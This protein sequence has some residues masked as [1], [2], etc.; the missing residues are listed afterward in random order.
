M[1]QAS[2]PKKTWE[3]ILQKMITAYQAP[4]SPQ[5]AAAIVDDPARTKG[6]K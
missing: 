5:D 4:I 3:K 2:M 1:T 6:M